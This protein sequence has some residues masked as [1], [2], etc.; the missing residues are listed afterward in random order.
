MTVRGSVIRLSQRSAARFVGAGVPFVPF[1][2]SLESE[3]EAPGRRRGAL[4]LWHPWR[5]S[6]KAR[7]TL[8]EACALVATRAAPPERFT[9]APLSGAAPRATDASRSAAREGNV[10][11][12]L[13][14]K[15]C[16]APGLMA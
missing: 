7:R 15:T 9:A 3:D 6:A 12:V 8:G 2:S 16:Q 13:E 11:I 14:A 4:A 1:F 5:A 10:N